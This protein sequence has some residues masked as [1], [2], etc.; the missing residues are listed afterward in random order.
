MLVKAHGNC[1][2]DP[3]AEVKFGGHRFAINFRAFGSNATTIIPRTNLQNSRY[4]AVIFFCGTP[5]ARRYLEHLQEEHRWANVSIRDMPK[6]DPVQA[7]R[8]P[9]ELLVRSLLAD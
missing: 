8:R 5:P 1:G 7:E 2:S 9:A 3:G 6:P 4:D